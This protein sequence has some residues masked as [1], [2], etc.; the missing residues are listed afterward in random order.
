MSQNKIRDFFTFCLGI[1]L[2]G[3]LVQAAGVLKGDQLV[4]PGV[5]EIL[6]IFFRQLLQ[7]FGSRLQAAVTLLVA[8]GVLELLEVIDIENLNTEILLIA[9]A[10]FIRFFPMA[11]QG[12]PVGK[13]RQ[14]IGLCLF[15]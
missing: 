12:I 1:V 3:V 5:G 2:I 9:I 10:A 6:R 15:Q 7:H 13:T 8:I 11:V 4:F 14:S